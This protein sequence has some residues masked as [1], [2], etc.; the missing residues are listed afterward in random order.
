MPEE[1]FFPEPKQITN[2]VYAYSIPGKK[3]EGLINI[4]F[5]SKSFEERINSNFPK[6]LLIML[7]LTKKLLEE[8]AVRNDG[9]FFMDH[10]V[11]KVLKNA[12]FKN[13]GGEWFECTVDDVKAAIVAVRNYEDIELSRIHDFKLRPE[14]QLAV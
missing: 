9:T 7:S 3:Y 12:G 6:N 11:H 4:G 10:A 5:T 1:F 8:P 14:Q 13:V 2:I